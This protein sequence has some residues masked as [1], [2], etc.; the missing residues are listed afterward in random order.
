MS[1][2]DARPLRRATV[3]AVWALAMAAALWLIARTPFS[4]DLSAFLP[5]SPEP[6]QRVLLEQLHS[7]VAAR[8]LLLGIE[9]G[10]APQRAEASRRLAATLR[11]S[12]RF[13]QVHNGEQQAWAAAGEWVFRHRYHLSPAV[14]AEHFSVEG[15]RAA[16]DDTL[17]LLGTPAG[18][19]FKPLLERDPTGEA[20]RIAEA[21]LPAQAPRSDDGVWASRRAPRAV[22]LLQGRASGGD[23]NAQA[24]LI[25]FVR[26]SFAAVQREPG[27]APLQLKLTGAPLFA[28][29][30]R[31]RIEGEVVELALVGTLVIG[32]LLLLAFG[33]LPAVAIA[34]VPVAT[35]VVAGIA[36]VAL[37]FGSVHG[38]TLGFG[39]T[40]IGESVDYA[41]YY[42]IQARAAAGPALA[43]AGWRSWLAQQWPTVRLGLL[44]SICGFA[45]LL[46]SGFPGLAQL[47]L[48][49]IA[50]L[51]GA[52][53][54][55]RWL[56]PALRPDGAAGQGLRRRLGA[57][58]A[59]GIVRLQRLRRA[60]W[61]LAA[62][63]IA[64]LAWPRGPLWH[65]DL[66]SLSP[67]PKAALALDAELRADLSAS[68]AG[69]LVVVQADS[70]EAALQAAEAAG[71]RLDALV[72]DGR[73]GGY[74]SAARW[75]PSLATQRA[76]IDSLPDAQ[77][78]STRLAEATAGGPLKAER[79]QPFIA[80]VQAA[81][82]LP[83]VNPAAFATTPLAPLLDALLFQRSGT[84][85]ERG[86]VALLPLQPGPQPLDAAAV[87]GALQ[88]LPAVQVV[89]IGQAL[90]DLYQR[91]L[92]EALWQSL[93]GA[94][95]LVVL[96]AV[97]LR[98]ARRLVGLCVPLA[99]AV[100]LTLAGLAAAGVP[101]GIL[102]L[103]GLLLVIA[104]GSNYALF[105]D[106][107]TQGGPADADTLAS[108]LLA[109]ATTVISFG[110]IAMSKI[111][112]LAAIGQVVA[113][114]ALLA[115][116]LSAACIRSRTDTGSR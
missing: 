86:W 75:L 21:L 9:G 4:A 96:L 33:S 73:L 62:L 82:G 74:D 45:A 72:A 64:V 1:A 57:V 42:L 95:A 94:A 113:P 116:L 16:I 24:A 89:D 22:L 40:L 90:G 44:T 29:D 76:R 8:T 19:P 61:L 92:R 106:Q 54:A 55:T 39:S 23:L 6:A 65:G 83:L 18:A 112:A 85:A 38:M 32:L 48:F 91:Y 115:L 2:A 36:A 47:G 11:A 10:T 63:A 51:C 88:A 68:D 35:G 104:V 20:Q 111:P 53:A 108:L 31:E 79:L 99:L 41:I 12:G 5:R 27:L 46:M 93:L 105:F 15:L 77:T 87:Q 43:G 103:V 100:L 14:T 17:S 3:L 98:S 80:E 97:A 81:R 56:L 84:A 25:R 50:G 28:V 114:G 70:A 58:A 69:T 52:A 66:S 34:F 78:L 26:D 13:E 37:G 7:G 102:H 101:L 109:N 71:A 30:S 107:L 110:L 60:A 49:S 59:V 67:V